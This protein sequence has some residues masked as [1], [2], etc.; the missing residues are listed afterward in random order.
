MEIGP[1]SNKP[2]VPSPADKPS[3]R[4]EPADT[5][6]LIRDSV[7]ISREAR[8]R[9]AQLADAALRAE[10]TGDGTTGTEKLREDKVEQARRRAQEGR[11]AVEPCGFPIP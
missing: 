7:E 4:P 6:V 3:G 10:K 9:L 2:P 11:P 1:L 5:G 8:R